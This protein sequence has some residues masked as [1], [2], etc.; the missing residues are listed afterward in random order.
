V[1]EKQVARSDVAVR[2]DNPAQTAIS[3]ASSPATVPTTPPP[4]SAGGLTIELPDSAINPVQ[5]VG[6][7]IVLEKAATAATSITLE[8]S[9]S[10]FGVVPTSLT[11]A[12]GA[13]EGVFDV[14][15]KGKATPGVVRITAKSGPT[16][17]SD[18]IT[19]T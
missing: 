2:T 7:R 13:K 16:T 15:P 19:Y 14:V 5:T 3:S 12:V 11:I 8:S 18:T 17:I 6:G 9:N 1:V 10:E 4:T